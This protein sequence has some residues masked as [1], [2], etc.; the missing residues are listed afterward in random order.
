MAGLVS[1]ADKPSEISLRR[2]FYPARSGGTLQAHLFEGLASGKRI[3]CVCASVRLQAFRH[4]P[5]CSGPWC[6]AGGQ[7]GNCRVARD[8]PALPSKSGSGPSMAV[9]PICWSSKDSGRRKLSGGCLCENWHSAKPG[10]EQAKAGRPA[11]VRAHYP[12]MVRGKAG[13]AT[14]AVCSK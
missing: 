4:P 11:A 5:C 12:T 6:I 14:D 9:W 8:D 1:P 13:S 2:P 3:C 7:G 10:V